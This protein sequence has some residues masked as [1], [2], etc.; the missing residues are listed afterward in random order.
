MLKLL[1]TTY[2]S[3][4]VDVKDN[5]GWTPLAKAVS[6]NNAACVKLLLLSGANPRLKDDRGWTCFKKATLTKHDEI[7]ELLFTKTKTNTPPP[8]SDATDR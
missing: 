3:S 8:A 5:Q 4:H 2:D 7:M 1:L 6:Y